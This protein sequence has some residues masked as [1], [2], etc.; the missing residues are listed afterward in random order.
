MLTRFSSLLLLLLLAVSAISGVPLHA[1]EQGEC[2]MEGMEMMDC[3]KKAQQQETVPEVASAKL[4]CAL[5]CQSGGPISPAGSPGLN[6][7]TLPASSP[8][9]TAAD[10]TRLMRPSVKEL[11]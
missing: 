5:N 10:A 3:C 2:P 11:F 1:A 6:I 4:C 7:Q 8:G 9:G